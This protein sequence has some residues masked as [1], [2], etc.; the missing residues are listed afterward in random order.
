MYLD[1]LMALENEYANS[2]TWKWN[3]L[4]N[5]PSQKENSGTTT[6]LDVSPSGKLISTSNSPGEI[7]VWNPINLNKPTVIKIDGRVGRITKL[8]FVGEKL[9]LSYSQDKIIRLWSLQNKQ[10]VFQLNGHTSPVEYLGISPCKRLICSVDKGGVVKAWNIKQ[11]KQILAVN[12]KKIHS[13]KVYL[14]IHKA[15]L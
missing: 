2:A 11:G 14:L 7:K 15:R 3:F 9:L 1:K 4:V 5:I 8:L 10:E 13:L 6:A 12:P